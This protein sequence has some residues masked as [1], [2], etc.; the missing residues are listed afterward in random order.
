MITIKKLGAETMSGRDLLE[1]LQALPPDELNQP[2]L[3][4][5]EECFWTVKSAEVCEMPICV[6]GDYFDPGESDLAIILQ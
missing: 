6:D 5:G 2:V 3:L 4:E 1:A